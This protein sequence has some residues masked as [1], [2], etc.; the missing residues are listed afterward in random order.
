[1][2]SEY[3]KAVEKNPHIIIENISPQTSHLDGLDALSEA[4]ES[5][6]H[7]PSQFMRSVEAANQA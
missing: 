5:G 6:R 1:M 4:E 7:L 2:S 3:K